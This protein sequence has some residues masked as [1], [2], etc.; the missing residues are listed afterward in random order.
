MN[1]VLVYDPYSTH[2]GTVW[3]HAA[4][5]GT[6]PRI[7][8]DF[9]PV[10]SST[11]LFLNQATIA[12]YDWVICHYSVRLPSD[13]F[14]PFLDEMAAFPGKKALFIQ[15]EYDHVEQT[16]EWMDRIGFDVV[17]TCVPE[18]EIE[19]VY[20]SQRLPDTRFVSVLTGYVPEWAE[21][22]N[23]WL[24][25][26]QREFDVGYRGRQLPWRY[27]RLGQMKYEIGREFETRNHGVFRTSISSSENDRIYGDAWPKFL[28]NCRFTLGSES[29]CN[30]FDWD[31][32]L[33]EIDRHF[34]ATHPQATF[35]DYEA[36]VIGA[37]EKEVRMNQI[38]P[39]IFEAI[40]TKTALLLHKGSYSG[41][42]VPYTHFWPLEHD[43]SN[44]DETVAFIKDNDAVSAMV[45]R[46]YADIV[47]SRKWNYQTFIESIQSALL[48]APGRHPAGSAALPQATKHQNFTEL[49]TKVRFRLPFHMD[50]IGEVGA[51]LKKA[52]GIPLNWR[53]TRLQHISSTRD[54]FAA[55]LICFLAR[56]TYYLQIKI[57]KH[58]RP[59]VPRIWKA[60][61]F[62]KDWT[63]ALE[64]YMNLIWLGVI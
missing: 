56:G 57:L 7:S 37:R 40:G 19:K 26:S 36:Q 12:G 43:F 46:A 10:R 53:A 8:M 34:I 41:V 44:W 27:G 22:K 21:A 59:T 17:F 38:S 30:V 33:A 52:S 24:P 49:M 25:H 1:A 51:E 39:R 45:E 20:P 6:M 3:D 42:L 48:E 11:N 31:G 54:L 4:S 29:G 28:E 16:R 50:Q 23:S 61:R 63:N 9:L 58:Y 32:T 13:V 62:P 14:A 64:H 60:L 18:A 2:I 47:Q 35:T 5:L 15:D 55:F